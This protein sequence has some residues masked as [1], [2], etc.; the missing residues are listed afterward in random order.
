MC[1][2][3]G[4][5]TEKPKT[6]LKKSTTPILPCPER[7][8]PPLFVHTCTE[9]HI[10]HSALH[11]YGA[12]NSSQ[13]DC[14]YV[15]LYQQ[16]RMG[17]HCIPFAERLLMSHDYILATCYI[18][19][20]GIL[21]DM[22]DEVVASMP[23]NFASQRKFEDANSVLVF[24]VK[25]FPE[26]D[27]PLTDAMLK[28]LQ[29]MEMMGFNEMSSK[30]E[31]NMAVML[32]GQKVCHQN[33]N[34]SCSFLWKSLRH[35]VT[36]LVTDV[37]KLQFNHP[38]TEIYPELFIK[39][40]RLR[41]CYSSTKLLQYVSKALLCLRTEIFFVVW[42]TDTTDKEISNFLEEN[43][44]ILQQLHIVLYAGSSLYL[45]LP[46]SFRQRHLTKWLNMRVNARR[47]TTPL[48]VHGTLQ[49]MLQLPRT[50]RS[51]F[52]RI[53][54]SRS[55][56]GAGVSAHL[57]SC[58]TFSPMILTHPL[59][60]EMA[61]AIVRKRCPL[62]RAAKVLRAHQS[63]NLYHIAVKLPIDVLEGIVKDVWRKKE[64]PSYL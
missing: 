34:Q 5:N 29:A 6:K 63:H 25:N 9:L 62:S 44:Y 32:A 12:F 21:R 39:L 26:D 46:P 61:D 17:N 28:R 14:C 27:A 37:P 52:A 16:N 51:L 8:R 35:Q 22:Y 24:R 50:T 43:E 54:R 4:P 30:D 20:S 13:L 47:L 18:F 36:A 48:D 33:W 31:E 42:L 11:H 64:S 19:R 1:E 59:L 45:I 2:V 58:K 40:T 38:P 49:E 15:P 10:V 60:P 56:A 41:T 3:R 23:Q 53:P 57:C 55:C 7:P